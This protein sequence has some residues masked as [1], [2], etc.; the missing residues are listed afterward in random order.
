[1]NEMNLW[2][3]IGKR[4]RRRAHERYLNERARQRELEGQDAQEAVRRAA[5]NSAV[6]Q[7]GAYWQGP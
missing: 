5:Q 3:R 4:R 7:Q 1:V 2:I 6:A